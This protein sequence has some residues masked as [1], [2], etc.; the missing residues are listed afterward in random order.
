MVSVDPVSASAARFGAGSPEF[1]TEPL[2]EETVRA[3]WAL[4]ASCSVNIFP[5]MF[6]VLSKD[7]F[8]FLFFFP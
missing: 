1:V 4:E 3:H 5:K 7:F 2:L 6:F 8:G